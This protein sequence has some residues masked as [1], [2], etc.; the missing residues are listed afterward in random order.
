MLV[1]AAILVALSVTGKLF[2]FN[3][4]L[5]IRLSYENLPIA[6]AGIM[7][8]PFAGFAVGICADLCGCL[9]VGYAV[10]PIITLGAGLIGFVGGNIVLFFPKRF[11]IAPMLIADIAGHIVGSVVVKTIGLVVYYGAEKGIWVLLGQ[12]T[13]TYTLISVL[14]CIVLVF[15]LS[16]KYVEKEVQKMFYLLSNLFYLYSH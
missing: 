11:S 13:L 7:F 16:N 4:G 1:F 12:R 14:E 15:L 9:V 10:N 2:A 8:G 5:D 6:I 3:I